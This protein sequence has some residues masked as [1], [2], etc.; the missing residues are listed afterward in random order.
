M[1]GVIRTSDKTPLTIGTGIKE[2]HLVLLSLANISASVHMKATSHAFSLTAY[3]LIPK[4]LNVSAPIQAAL[5]AC[6]YHI[7]T[8]II[9]RNLRIADSHGA[10][11]SDPQGR[12]RKCHTPLASW[13]GDLPEQRTIACVL[14]SQSTIS[15]ATFDDFGDSEPHPPCTCKFTLDHI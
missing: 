4:F 6:V 1:L 8:S 9:T 15:T 3:L 14:A 11:L 12:R 2:M 7:C 13:I 10:E 5:T